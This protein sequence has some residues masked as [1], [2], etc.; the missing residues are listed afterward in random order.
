MQDFELIW[1]HYEQELRT[2]VLS[3]V[4]DIEIQKEI[5]QEIALKVFTSLHL[6]K[7]HLGGWLYV[8]TK[9]VIV[10]HYRK[11]NRPLPEPEVEVKHEEHIMQECLLPMLKN[12]SV[13]EQEILQLIQIEQYSLEE[14]VIKKNLSHSAVKSRLFRAKKALIK[15]FFSCCEYERNLRGEVVDFVPK[16]GSTC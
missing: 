5:M 16:N 3:R 14:V 13:E 11:V 15:S 10:D 1:S 8:L 12:L 2:Y 7:E 6:Q 9:N 4:A